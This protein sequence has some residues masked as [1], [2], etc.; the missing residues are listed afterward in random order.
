MSAPSAV[1]VTRFRV[2]PRGPAVTVT[3]REESLTASV[4]GVPVYSF[5]GSGRLL[6][7]FVGDRTYRRG[8]DSRMVEIRSDV[9]DGVPVRRRRAVEPGERRA[10]LEGVHGQM[11]AIGDALSQAAVVFADEA[12]PEAARAALAAWWAR[13]L[14]RDPDRLE[15]DEASFQAIYRPISVL[16]PD[17]YLAVVLQVTQGCPYNACTFCDFYRDRPFRIKG[18]AEI[19]EHIA[20]VK[21]FLGE[22]LALRRTIFLADAN[23]LVI[24]Q[25]ALLR[26]FDLLDVEF[27]PAERGGTRRVE[28]QAKS[29]QHAPFEETGAV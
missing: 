12:D 21:R 14:A 24:P 29:C 1:H 25:A 10:I 3:T 6:S 16:P 17:Q 26:L 2:I 19:R 7:V 18:E 8:L 20:A 23:A 15:A 5:D 11:R 13:I 22:G 27:P 28:D 9:E 4:N